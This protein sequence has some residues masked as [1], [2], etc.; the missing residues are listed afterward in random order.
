MADIERV[1]CG[2]CGIEMKRV[3]SNDNTGIEKW[4]CAW[5]NCPT[6]IIIHYDI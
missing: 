5:N 4:D 6:T 3:Y 2:I 1:V